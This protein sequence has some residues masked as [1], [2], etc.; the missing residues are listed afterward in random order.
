M[1]S[2]TLKYCIL[3]LCV[4]GIST[5][6]VLFKVS[7]N[8]MKTSNSLL[9]LAFDPW[10]IVALAL[11]GVV[12]IGWVWCLQEVPLSRAYLFMSLAFVLVPSMGW[13]VFGEAF[14]WKYLMGAFL[15][16][17]GIIFSVMG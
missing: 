8:A 13:L 4:F 17:C 16:I 12:T 15:I 9:S 11:Y 5:G 14:T 3:V 6:H 10:F 7:A 1:S 2:L